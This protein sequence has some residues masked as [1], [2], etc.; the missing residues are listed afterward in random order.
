MRRS[1]NVRLSKHISETVRGCS[2]SAARLRQARS[3][4]EEDVS[5]SWPVLLTAQICPFCLPELMV[6]PAVAAEQIGGSFAWGACADGVA[7]AAADGPADA[8][9]RCVV[10][11]AVV[12]AGGAGAAGAGAL[13][14]EHL[15]GGPAV[16]FS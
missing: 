4:A 10:H 6:T 1:D 2:Y 12:A 14:A 11:D 5:D 16:Q 7:G 9:Q 13:A 8:G 3:S 15:R